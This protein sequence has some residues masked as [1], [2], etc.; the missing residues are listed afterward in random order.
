[1]VPATIGVSRTTFLHDDKDTSV[2]IIFTRHSVGFLITHITVNNRAVSVTSYIN[3]KTFKLIVTVRW[4]ESTQC[5]NT[6]SVFLLC[7]VLDLWTVLRFMTPH[8]ACLCVCETD[9]RGFTKKRGWECCFHC[10]GDKWR[11]VHCM[12]VR[13]WRVCVCVWIVL[14]SKS[15]CFFIA[16]DVNSAVHLW[17]CA[18]A[19]VFKFMCVCTR[20]SC[21]GPDVRICLLATPNINQ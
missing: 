4:P 5:G 13:L 7:E 18:L 12:L 21:R 2:Q 11:C 20:R 9:F 16:V 8:Y 10:H 6:S 19:N 1:M 3:T 17:T 14:A 15:V